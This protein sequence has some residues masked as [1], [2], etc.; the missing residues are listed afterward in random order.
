MT[1]ERWSATCE[2]C[3]SID[4][5]RFHREGRLLAGQQFSWSWKRGNEPSGSINI[6]A[7]ADTLVL[8]YRW[9]SWS[10]TEWKTVEQQ[11]PITW[12]A[13]HLGGQRPWFVCSANGRY[14]GRRVAVLYG[15]G[16]FFACRRC[17]GLAYASQ[18]EAVRHLGLGRAQKIRMRLG[19]S[20]SILEAFPEKPLHMHWRT[21]E[22]L[23]RACETAE[24]RCTQGPARFLSALE[25]RAA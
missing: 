9:R 10:A 5:R 20:A 25:K 15:A 1:A 19:G 13:C 12:T 14:C 23:R 11:V 4:V 16:E 22:R 21:Y 24:A 2:S 7:E 3:K 18:Q 6:R 17:H 8:T